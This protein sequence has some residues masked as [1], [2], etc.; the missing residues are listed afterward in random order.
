MPFLTDLAAELT[1]ILLVTVLVAL[2]LVVSL[3]RAD[4]DP[5]SHR[6]T[7]HLARH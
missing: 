3:S 4:S 1:G 5:R 2:V 7:R 6:R